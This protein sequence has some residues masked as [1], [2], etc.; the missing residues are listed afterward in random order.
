MIEK[1]GK[2]VENKKDFGASLTGF[3]EGFDGICHDLLSAKLHT[4]AWSFLACLKID[5]GCL[6]LSFYLTLIL[7]T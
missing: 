5:A 4:Y 7:T 1:Q 2:A 6:I 3:S